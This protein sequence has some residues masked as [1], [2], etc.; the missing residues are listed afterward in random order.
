MNI[1]ELERIM[2]E[3]G[4]NIC[5]VC[6]TPFSKKHSRQQ[7]CGAEECKRIH[8]NKYLRERRKRLI[9][10][11]KEAFN[12][13]HAEAQWKSRQKKRAEEQAKR[14]FAKVQEHWERFAE[15]EKA[16]SGIDYGKRQAEKTLASVSKI[17]VEAFMR[18]IERRKE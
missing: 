17:D 8:H 3:A 4:V 7:T 1:S 18:E 15:S 6:G 11:D 10:E 12:R 16:V 5:P 13:T 9:T 2:G 14:N